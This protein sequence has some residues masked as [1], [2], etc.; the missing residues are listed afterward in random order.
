MRRKTT[1]I[2]KRT[3]KSLIMLKNMTIKRRKSKMLMIWIKKLKINLKSL[4]NMD[5]IKI[6]N[7]KKPEKKIMNLKR[8][9]LKLNKRPN[10]LNISSKKNTKRKKKSTRSK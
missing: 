4:I 3:K 10:M 2:R 8:K 6:K 9:L 1:M 7:Y 5:I